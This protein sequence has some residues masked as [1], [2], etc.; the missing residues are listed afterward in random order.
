MVLIRFE[1]WEYFPKY[2]GK[3]HIYSAPKSNCF[4]ATLA[5]GD[6]VLFNV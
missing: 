6:E 4:V 5:V 3:P 2:V 1:A